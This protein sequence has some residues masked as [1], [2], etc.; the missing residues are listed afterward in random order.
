[1]NNLINI[2]KDTFLIEE[3]NEIDANIIS[4]SL[5][6]KILQEL[7]KQL[8]DIK[9]DVDDKI[10]K[11][12]QEE[13]E[14]W[15]HGY[16]NANYNKVFRD[17]FG[18]GEIR[19]DKITDDD[20][21]HMYL[22]NEK[23]PKTERKI[24]DVI[25]SKSDE[26][27]LVKDKDDKKFL[28]VIYTWGNVYKLSSD[29]RVGG[30]NNYSGQHVVNRVGRHSKDIT[31]KE[32]I[33]LCRD[34]NLYFINVH[35]KKEEA[36]KLRQQRY[37]NKSGIILLDPESLKEIAKKNI[38][39]YKEI[40]RKKRATN[41]NNDELLNKCKK[42]INQVGIYATM[43]AKDPIRHADLISLVSTLSTWIYDKR[44]YHSPSRYNK[45]GYYSGVNG[46]LPLISKYTSLIKDLS[47]N[48]GYE[49]QQNSLNVVQEE[50]KKSIEKAESIIKQIEDKMDE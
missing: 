11:E 26:V 18:G 25:K 30:Y 45:Q 19:W 39:R 46:L 12:Y 34:K 5:N 1:M 36:N 42:I 50:M 48:G 37:L 40:L 10:E 33:E 3:F 44:E 2:I 8:K 4:E 31:N 22:G 15:G 23:N 49:H 32:K 43:V 6:C 13:V 35:D 29:N 7:A 16:K 17:I 24:Q 21:E 27:I 41:L 14:R 9:I 28:Y 20:I 38:E 47:K